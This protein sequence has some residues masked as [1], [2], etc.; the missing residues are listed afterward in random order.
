MKFDV[1]GRDV[2]V[3]WNHVVVSLLSLIAYAV[4]ILI[5]ALPPAYFF[6]LPLKYASEPGGSGIMLIQGAGDYGRA[7]ASIIG[8]PFE[9]FILILVASWL[10]KMT[11]DAALCRSLSGAYFFVTTGIYLVVSIPVTILFLLGQLTL[12]P[13]STL[14][15]QLAGMLLNILGNATGAI[16]LYLWLLA[17]AEPDMQKAKKTIIPAAVFGAALA[18]FWFLQVLPWTAPD[19]SALIQDTIIFAVGQ[20]MAGLISAFLLNLV[21]GFIILYHLKGKKLDDAAYLFAALIVASPLLMMMESLAISGTSDL[22]AT[23]TALVTLALLYG[24]SRIDL[25]GI[26]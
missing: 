2:N 8:I 20:H 10:Y 26:L 21:L 3:G 11:K 5:V 16:L 13:G 12:L 22:W 19:Q 25:K 7:I 24:L 6:Y 14:L 15:T 4:I 1:L 9:A 17:I 18:L 23:L